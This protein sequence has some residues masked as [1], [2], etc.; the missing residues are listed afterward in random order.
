MKNF[1]L[2]IF[3]FLLSFNVFSLSDTY[4]AIDGVKVLS[5]R[6]NNEKSNI[7][8]TLKKGQ[9]IQLLTMHHSGWSL[10]SFNGLG[11]WVLSESLTENA[12]KMLKNQDKTI[13]ALASSSS[14]SEGN[15]LLEKMKLE[16]KDLQRLNLEIRTK[17]IALEEENSALKKENIQ[18]ST[19]RN[20]GSLKSTFSVFFS[21]L[22]SNW[23]YL[24]SAVL[25]LIAVIAFIG[26]RNSKRRRFDL[27][28]IKRSY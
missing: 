11:G 8:T 7:V 9:K 20:K 5:D 13:F 1:F 17:N 28:T 2:L 21:I 25:A 26:F 10:V 15:E 23:P 27:N 14:V 3:A 22:S 12:P 16:L 24:I 18:L 19:V 4:V 6:S